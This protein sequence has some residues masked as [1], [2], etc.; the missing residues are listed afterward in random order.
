VG[1]IYTIFAA[2]ELLVKDLSLERE[3]RILLVDDEPDILGMLQRAISREWPRATIA[4]AHDAAEAERNIAEHD[5]DVV[6]SDYRMPGKDGVSILSDVRA[7]HARTIRILFTAHPE[8]DAAVRA[9]NDAHVERFLT[10]PIDMADFAQAVK[11]A[12]DSKRAGDVRAAAFAR[13]LHVLNT[14]RRASPPDQDGQ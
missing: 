4:L 5:W 2:R 12:W 6:V 8:L 9:I 3:P 1:S 14:E 13:T 11:K 10:K 7:H